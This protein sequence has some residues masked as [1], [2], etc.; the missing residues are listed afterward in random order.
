MSF[1]IV[2]AEKEAEWFKNC[3]DSEDLGK[4]NGNTDWSLLHDSETEDY[5]DAVDDGWTL[6]GWVGQKKE[7]KNEKEK[8]KLKK[9][10]K[11]RVMAAWMNAKYSK[12]KV[13]LTLKHF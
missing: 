5:E 3:Y 4:V 7:S 13:F 8:Q 11:H 2:G 9:S 12:F 10:F 1:E 6:K